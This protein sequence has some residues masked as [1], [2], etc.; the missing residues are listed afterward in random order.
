MRAILFDVDDTL[1]DQVQPFRRAYEKLYKKENEDIDRIFVASRKY[2]DEVF[3][4]SARGLITMEQMYIYRVREAFREYNL[5]ISEEAA[6]T[7]QRYYQEFQMDIRMSAEIEEMLSNLKGRVK[8]G[9]ITNGPT[10]HQWDKVRA[11]GL[12]RWI[13]V[14]NVLISGEAGAAKPDRKIFDIAAERMELDIGETYFVG[15]SLKN[16]VAGAANA[17]WKTIWFNRRRKE[18]GEEVKPD[19]TVCSEEELCELMRRLPEQG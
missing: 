7:F 15:D 11:L 2:G 18:P 17:G 14:Q 12:T 6:L 10:E 3:E 19:C 5:F 13:P 4:A 16:D 8:L 9:L 1:Y